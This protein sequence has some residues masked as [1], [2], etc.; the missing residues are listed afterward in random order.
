LALQAQARLLA[1]LQGLQEGGSAV[2][3][4]LQVDY[5]WSVGDIAWAVMLR[6]KEYQPRAVAA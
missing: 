4:N 6:E 1:F 2:G 5:R 3:R